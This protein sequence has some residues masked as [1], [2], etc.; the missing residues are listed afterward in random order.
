M[1]QQLLPPQLEKHP[2]S[3]SSKSLFTILMYVGRFVL[4]HIFFENLQYRIIYGRILQI[5]LIV[6]Y[7]TT[8]DI[9][10]TRN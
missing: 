2:I 4:F 6:W 1:I 3:E 8:L 9:V 7:S 10:P 5:R